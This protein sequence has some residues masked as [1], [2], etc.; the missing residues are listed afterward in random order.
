MRGYLNLMVTRAYG[1]PH[2]I[3]ITTANVTDI[4]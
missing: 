4:T 2:A 3:H 1:L